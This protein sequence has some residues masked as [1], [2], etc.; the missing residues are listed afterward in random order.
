MPPLLTETKAFQDLHQKRPVHSIISLFH[1]HF[2]AS[3][4]PLPV[5]HFSVCITFKQQS[6]CF[7]LSIRH[8]RTLIWGYQLL[9]NLLQ[10]VRQ[11]FLNYLVANVTETNRTVMR[12][13]LW[14]INLRDQGYERGVQLLQKVA[15][16][17]KYFHHPYHIRVNHRPIFLIKGSCKPIGSRC[18]R[19]SYAFYSRP[20]LPIIRNLG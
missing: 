10:P 19:P 20:F 2:T 14:H 12:N 5:F 16:I 11:G 9:Q 4:P 15:I 13:S 6:G 1:S 8:K 3:K 7:E 17:E 18:L